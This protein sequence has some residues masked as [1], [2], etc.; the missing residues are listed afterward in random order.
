M[1]Q[2]KRRIFMGAMC[3]QIAYS[4]PDGVR[5]IEKYDPEKIRKDR[6][7]DESIYSKFKE[8]I[9]RRNHLRMFH[10]NFSPTSIYGTLTFDD[11]YEVHTFCE[12][13]QVARNFLRVLKYGFPEAVI[14]L[15]MG[16]GK[17]TQRIHFHMVSEG[18][19]AE[20]ISKKWKYGSVKRFDN[21]REHCWY[22]GV[23]HGQDYTGLANYLFDHWTEEVGGHRW[24]MTKNA[25][26]PER[27]EPTEVQIRGGY[28][29]KRPPVAPRGYMLV[30]IKAT[31][32]GCYHFIYVVIP[33]KQSREKKSEQHRHSGRL[34]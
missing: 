34:D 22:Q 32:Y 24:I 16:R 25:K 5:N 6:F 15:Y 1:R 3:E 12:A 13:K 30:D 10:A 27:E 14:F 2:M 20:F 18:I 26:K 9:S 23:D 17:S 33:P 21:L 28:S 11:D 31:K 29:E 4:V 7:E 8:N 19:P